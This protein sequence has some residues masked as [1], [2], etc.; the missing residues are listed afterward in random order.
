MGAVIKYVLIP[1]EKMQLMPSIESQKYR[2]NV[3]RT[4]GLCVS[5]RSS[6]NF[7]MQQLLYQRHC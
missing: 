3:K 2:D 7:I 6:T 4:N 1:S 5:V